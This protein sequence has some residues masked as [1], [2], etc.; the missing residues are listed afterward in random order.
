MLTFGDLHKTVVMRACVRSVANEQ[1]C[2]K[3]LVT[4]TPRRFAIRFNP[5]WMLRAECVVHLA[6]KF[7]V[8]G[9]LSRES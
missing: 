9:N 1:L 8:T 4:V 5:L 6:L 3:R 2:E 7:N